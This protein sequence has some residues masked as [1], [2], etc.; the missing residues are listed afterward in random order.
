MISYRVKQ[1]GETYPK[2]L[3]HKEISKFSVVKSLLGGG[4]RTPFPTSKW[5]LSV[6]AMFAVYRIRCYLSFK[7]SL[8]VFGKNI[9]NPI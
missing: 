2:N 1:S 9:K 7:I 5:Q 3:S 6:V 4:D 8:N